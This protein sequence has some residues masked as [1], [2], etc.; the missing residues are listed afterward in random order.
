MLIALTA[1]AYGIWRWMNVQRQT[2]QRIN[3]LGVVHNMRLPKQDI[4][5]IQ[6]SVESKKSAAYHR[7]LAEFMC[8]HLKYNEVAMKLNLKPIAKNAY[9]SQETN[10]QLDMFLSDPVAQQT[11]EMHAKSA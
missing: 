5:P 9:P 1:A 8:N 11:K 2:K 3:V 4:L 7:S 6:P 10:V